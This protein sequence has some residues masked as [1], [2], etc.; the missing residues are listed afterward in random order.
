MDRSLSRGKRR[1]ER[2]NIERAI[3][4]LSRSWREHANPAM[5][6]LLSYLWRFCQDLHDLPRQLRSLFLAKDWS[7]RLRF[8]AFA[9]LSLLLIWLVAAKSYVAYLDAG[10]AMPALAAQTA[11]ANDYLGR[12]EI[13]LH[14]LSADTPPQPATESTP[15]NG[16]IPFGNNTPANENTLA[17]EN[18]PTTIAE[19]LGEPAR[20]QA[21]SLL[22]HQPLDARAL[23]ILAEISD[24]A[25]DEPQASTLM[26]AAARRSLQETRAL[27]WLVAKRFRQDDFDGTAYYADALLRTRPQLVPQVTPVLARLAENQESVD[28][29]EKL[30]AANPPWRRA[31]FRALPTNV[32]DVRTPLNLF[33]NLRETSVP[34][35]AG[36]LQAYLNFLIAQQFAEVAYYTWL[37][38]LPQSELTSFGF[39]YNGG[40]E[41]EPSKLPFDWVIGNG[42]GVIIDMVPPP[43]DQNQRA[44]YIEFGYGR[45]NFRGVTQIV[46]IPP[47]TYQLQGKYKGEIL[48]RRGLRWRI[49]CID[50]KRLG[51]SD[52]VLGTK[53]DWQRFDFE[54]TVPDR[55]CSAQQV[56]LVL[57]S[58]S[59]SEQFVTGSIWYD[60]LQISRHQSDAVTKPESR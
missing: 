42:S 49:T 55:D 15:P 4:P 59:A 31:F 1:R 13:A 38:F 28:A 20:I 35:E 26:Q 43:E 60:D 44:L 18:L 56:S 12:A 36:D 22:R 41:A 27:A 23:R 39:L 47:G 9:A 53:P 46:V 6:A 51:E 2:R 58:R 45:V 24:A 40:F 5:Q 37:Q 17:N 52:M 10:N 29:L 57:D 25:G 11:D 3:D 34:P 7:W 8:A 21:Q 54:F 32:S 48:G 30:L 33:L 16:N 19:Q 14:A 50:G